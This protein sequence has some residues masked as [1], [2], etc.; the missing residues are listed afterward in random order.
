MHGDSFYAFHASVDSPWAC[1][2][3]VVLFAM[4]WEPLAQLVEEPWLACSP[5]VALALGLHVLGNSGLEEAF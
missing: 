1:V 3:P 5:C 2:E 4:T